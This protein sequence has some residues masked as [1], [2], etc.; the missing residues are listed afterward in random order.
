MSPAPSH[1]CRH[2][3]SHVHC[4]HLASAASSVTGKLPPSDLCR[5]M[6]YSHSHCPICPLLAPEFTASLSSAQSCSP[7]HTVTRDS[8]H[9]YL[10]L[11]MNV[12]TC[13]LLPLSRTVRHLHIYCPCPSLACA[14]TC[15]HVTTSPCLCR[16]IPSLAHCTKLT[17]P[18]MRNHIPND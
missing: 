7:K 6:H 3:Y 15:S 17:S 1:P 2:P 11:Q 12:F 4:P 18:D 10:S 13:P 8:T 16:R 14:V 5:H 9:L